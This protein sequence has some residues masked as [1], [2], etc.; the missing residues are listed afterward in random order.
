[1]QCNDTL[2]VFRYQGKDNTDYRIAFY[3]G[4][5]HFVHFITAN[6]TT[7][8]KLKTNKSGKTYVEYSGQFV[9]SKKGV[10]YI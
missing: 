3:K 8:F 5:Y 1:M 9:L 10:I 2:R 7:K 4:K 6:I